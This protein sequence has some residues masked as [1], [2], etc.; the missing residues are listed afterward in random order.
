MK[1]PTKS[2]RGDAKKVADIKDALGKGQLDDHA[3]TDLMLHCASVLAYRRAATLNPERE[4]GLGA[5]VC[6]TAS[7]GGDD[8]TIWSNGF[9]VGTSTRQ[10][11]AARRIPACG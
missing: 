1:K 11:A 2:L 6:Y 3:V 10:E 9:I 8:V 7:G 4:A 5:G